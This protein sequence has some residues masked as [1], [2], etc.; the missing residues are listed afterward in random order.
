MQQDSQA[1]VRHARHAQAEFEQTRRWHL[2]HEYASGRCDERIGRF[3]YW[4][5]DGSDEHPPPEPRPIG[6]ARS[7]LVGVLDSAARLLPGDG[8]IAGQLVRYLVEDERARDALAAARA[9]RAASWWCAAL[10]GFALHAARD[11]AAADSAY[12]LA[13]DSMPAD[14]RCRWTDVSVLL[15]GELARR[16]RPLGCADREALAARLWWLA[17]PLLSVPGND[18]RTEH[19]ARITMTRLAKDARTAYGIAWSW[20]LDELTLRY[21]WPAW[22]ARQE[23]RPGQLDAEAGVIG[24]EAA[25]GLHFIPDGHAV[26]DPARAREDDWQP[27]SPGARERYQPTYTDTL[28]ALPHQTA[29]FH[30]GDSALVVAA[31]DLSGDARFQGVTLEAALVLA[32]DERTA[33]RMGRLSGA[34]SQGVLTATAPWAPLLVSL[35]VI[36]PGT[37]RAARARHGWR[38]AS[39]SGRALLSDLLMFSPPDP[40]DLPDQPALPEPPDSLPTTLAAALPH[41]LSSEEV[42]SDRKL[43]LYWELYGLDP[44]GQLVTTSVAV[45]PVKEGWLHRLAAGVGVAAKRKP[46][47]LEWQEVPEGQGGLSGRALAIDLSGL[48]SGRYRIELTVRTAAGESATAAREI[49]VVRP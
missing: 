14:E 49:R 44:P 1:I 3:C 6:L 11:F 19:F 38:A 32:P 2:P 13:L 8:W 30:H 47:R 26:L 21:A 23:P 27:G 31:Y 17:Q 12:G 28:V 37:R 18:R 34:R 39:A 43:G 20:D 29:V 7:R 24:H 33:P 42:R 9:C 45:V 25:P 36:A 40:P 35:E 10:A 4:P 5:G 22:W 16:Y 15:D 48:A 46:V 41:A